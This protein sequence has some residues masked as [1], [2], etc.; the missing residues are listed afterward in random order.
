MMLLRAACG[1]KKLEVTSVDTI[2]REELVGVLTLDVRRGIAE[3]TAE[4]L[5]RDDRAIDSVR[6]AESTVRLTHLA[7]T[8]QRLDGGGADDL[9]A[10]GEAIGLGDLHSV[11]S[12]KC[13]VILIGELSSRT[14]AI[15]I[16]EEEIRHVELL[17]QDFADE[18]L[19][20]VGCQLSGEGHRHDLKALKPPQSLKVAV[21]RINV[22]TSV[23]TQDIGRV[24][25][26]GQDDETRPFVAGSIVAHL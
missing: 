26:K 24:R 9:P 11:L 1:T 25:D 22:L 7:T 8:Y 18:G 2:R 19:G 5:P 13:L 14:E 16:A 3:A 10:E 23:R 15:V 4:L 21:G 17:M 20:G 6:T 12:S